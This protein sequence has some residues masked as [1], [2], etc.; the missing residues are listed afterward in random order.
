MGGIA[1][2]AESPPEQSQNALG[3]GSYQTHLARTDHLAESDQSFLR[4]QRFAEAVTAY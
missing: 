2:N 4:L 1:R 3:T